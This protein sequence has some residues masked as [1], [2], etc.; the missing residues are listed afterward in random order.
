MAAR[1]AGLEAAACTFSLWKTGMHSD[2]SRSFVG[3]GMREGISAG[4]APS[5][6]SLALRPSHP[7]GEGE[8]GM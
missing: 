8:A 1:R 3:Q 5:P 6:I 2:A 4:R 7:I